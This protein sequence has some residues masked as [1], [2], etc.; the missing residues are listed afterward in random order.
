MLEWVD[1]SEICRCDGYGEGKKI[2]SLYRVSLTAIG[3]ISKFWKE[4]SS[5]A[6]KSTGRDRSWT[7][8]YVACGRCHLAHAAWFAHVPYLLPS[9]GGSIPRE[10][11]SLVS[12]LS[13]TVDMN[14]QMSELMSSPHNFPL[15]LF[16]EVTKIPYFCY[17]QVK[18]VLYPLWINAE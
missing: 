15:I 14:M 4:K 18:L 11:A 9:H 16:T 7:G 6:L 5:P 3:W 10:P 8:D 1:C 13:W 12:P 17:E 2:L